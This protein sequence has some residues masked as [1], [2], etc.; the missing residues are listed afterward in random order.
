VP[1]AI[2]LAADAFIATGA[3]FVLGCLLCSFSI[4]LIRKRNSSQRNSRGSDTGSDR[5]WSIPNLSCSL[6]R[7][8]RPSPFQRVASQNKAAKFSSDSEK[9]ERTESAAYCNQSTTKQSWLTES[10]ETQL[11][12]PPRTG[13]ECRAHISKTPKAQGK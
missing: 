12:L 4:P 8:I 9:H 2:A 5:R 3:V 1:C 10:L 7:R 6:R 13:A 11:S